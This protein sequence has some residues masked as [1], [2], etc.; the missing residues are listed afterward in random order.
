MEPS[1]N[2]LYGSFGSLLTVLKALR[3]I[4][5]RYF[6]FDADLLKHAPARKHSGL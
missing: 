2:E 5:L 6:V 4:T 1:E 3:L